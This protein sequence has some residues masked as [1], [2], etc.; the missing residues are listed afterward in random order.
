CSSDLTFSYDEALKQIWAFI[1]RGNKYIDETMPW[2][3]NK[4]EK[5][6]RLKSVLHTLYEVLRLSALL[7]APY[8][9][10]SAGK[11]WKQL[12]CGG[13]PLSEQLDE[14]RW[15]GGA[16]TKVDKAEVLFPRIDLEQ[17][18]KDRTGASPKPEEKETV[19][20]HEAEIDID[21]FRSVEMRVAQIVKAEEIPRSKKLYKLEVDLGYERRT[22]CSG[23]RN[24][25]K[26]EELEG[27]RV[28][29]VTNL[30]PAKLCGVE[31]NGMILAASAG[32]GDNERV[33]LVV[34]AADVPLGSRVR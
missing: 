11:I 4:E 1:G 21:G 19:A 17:W 23:I 32:E 30:K 31:S 3:L 27:R 16:G 34:P 20:Q 14:F 6:E 12:G 26:P 10:E 13:S 8:I 24:F 18:K 7:V 9:P 2:K 29:M 28:V 25:F 15:G 33:V 5:T 22:I